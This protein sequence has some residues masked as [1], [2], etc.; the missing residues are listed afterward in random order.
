MSWTRRQ[1]LQL[2]ATSFALAGTSGCRRRRSRTAAP[3]PRTKPPRYFVLLFLDG[4][5]DPVLTVNPM[6]RDQVR[7][8]VDVPYG[9]SE[10]SE[11]G[12][13]RLG[14][15]FAPLAPFAS[16]MA[17]VNGVHLD[18]ANHLTGHAQIAR[19][20]TAALDGMPGILDILG[21]H[22]ED[23]P[24]AS[25]SFGVS[26]AQHYTPSY[27]DGN[28]VFAIH[29]AG[30][31]P[32]RR[33]SAGLHAQSEALRA[34]DTGAR[35]QRTAKNVR[36]IAALAERLR[37]V[38]AF[39]PVAWEGVRDVALAEQFQ[40]AVW[41]LEHNLS[42]CVFM[43]LKPFG[44]WDSHNHN[45]LRQATSSR[46]FCR[47]FTRFLGELDSRRNAAGALAEQTTTIV[48]SE[49]G[50]FPR[51]NGNQ[52]KDHFPEAPYIFMGAG[53]NTGNG[54]GRVFGATDERMAAVPIDLESGQRASR[55]GH[56]LRLDDLGT[57][58]LASAGIAPEP[59]GYVGK[60][61]PFL[62]ARG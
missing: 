62:M 1:I 17:I 5:I 28:S 25:V 29:D 48:G 35:I 31:E 59:R 9:P 34:A 8:E 39:R 50:R 6:T 7:A 21:E 51:L 44:G 18:T 12:A 4:G 16:R 23:Q 27:A 22:G 33:M 15:H 60:V 49:I 61:L 40:R 11:T 26:T 55:G 2:G 56:K 36:R 20:R 32:L 10:I 47:L 37:E 19:L 52:G 57:T 38:P 54:E 45:T 53:V 42:R 46:E 14:P 13:V 58:L 3:E 24:L 41:V 43:R 30:N